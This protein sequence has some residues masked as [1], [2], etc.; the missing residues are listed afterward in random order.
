MY[1]APLMMLLGAALLS[2]ASCWYAYDGRKLERPQDGAYQ[3]AQAWADDID[4]S[5][6]SDDEHTTRV[7]VKHGVVS[8]PWVMPAPLLMR[9]GSMVH[10][11]HGTHYAGAPGG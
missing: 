8:D 3:G 1:L 2:L 9:L 4:A 7:L 11:K 5:L 6:E 10:R